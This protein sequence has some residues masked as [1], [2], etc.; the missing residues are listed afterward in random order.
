MDE[1]R[2]PF[3][4]SDGTELEP[5]TDANGETVG[6]YITPPEP[7]W[8]D[9]D[10]LRDIGRDLFANLREIPDEAGQERGLRAISRMSLVAT[11]VYVLEQ[12]TLDGMARDISRIRQAPEA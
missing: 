7:A 11:L 4:A 6:F 10:R 9:R 1:Q 5:V 3:E 8:P 2:E 12:D